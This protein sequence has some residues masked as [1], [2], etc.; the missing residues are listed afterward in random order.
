MA[1]DPA[2]STCSFDVLEDLVRFGRHPDSP[3]LLTAYLAE[4][5]SRHDPLSA[6]AWGQGHGRAHRL[7]LDAICDPLVPEHWRWLCLDHLWLP[8]DRLLQ[9]ASSRDE[10][11]VIYTASAS[12]SVQVHDSL[13]VVR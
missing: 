4:M 9:L 7:L 13:G 2:V 8:L 6:N 10:R 3:E 12:A 1:E 11:A 5:H